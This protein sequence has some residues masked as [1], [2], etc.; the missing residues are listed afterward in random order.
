MNETM[1]FS[2]LASN[3]VRNAALH[4]GTPFE[5]LNAWFDDRIR[6]FHKPLSTDL[7]DERTTF[8]GT[9]FGIQFYLH[10]DH[11]GNFFHL[12]LII[13]TFMVF[14]LSF[15]KKPESTNALVGIYAVCIIG[16]FAILSLLIK[17]NPWNSRYHLPLFVMIC[18]FVGM[19]LEKR[20]P[21][22]AATTVLCALFLSSIPWMVSNNSR[23]LFISPKKFFSDHVTWA[24]K[25]YEGLGNIFSVGRKD[26]L[27]CNRPNLK[28]PY[29]GAVSFLKQQNCFDIGLI[30]DGNE[31]EYPFWVLM[32]E[33]GSSAYRMEHMAVSGLSGNLSPDPLAD[34]FEP[35]AVIV[36]GE[37]QPEEVLIKGKIYQKRWTQKPVAILLQQH[38]DKR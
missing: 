24:A 33:D 18:P 6:A 1:N 2:S 36:V 10:E 35:C 4:V 14:L 16:G 15:R 25:T 20:I 37:C 34:V 8:P 7:N 32:A 28:A 30:L 29:Q 17:W 38:P 19:V 21:N 22:Q 13:F 9:K 26:Q 27:F 11:S 23:P 31:W 12:I 5:D 3:M